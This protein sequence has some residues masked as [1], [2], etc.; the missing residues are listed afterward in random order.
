[1][2]DWN[3]VVIG[4]FGIAA[5]A[6]ATPALAA[7][8]PSV[9]DAYTYRLVN[10][11]NKEL[12]ALVRYQVSGVEPDRVSYTVTPDQAA[13]GVE[14]T[15][16]YSRDGNWLRVPL[17]SHGEAVEYAFATAYPA[18]VFPL[19]PGKS[20]SLRVKASVESARWG[21]RSVRVDGA[22]LGSERVRVPAGEFDTIK[23]RRYVYPGDAD[24]LITETRIVEFDWYAP[25][26]GRVV[27]S[28][29]RSD[30]LD[31]S[32]CNANMGCDYYGS[33][34]V[35]ELAEVRPARS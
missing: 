25:A 22:V 15:E 18:L 13:G 19:E 21:P 32:R 16:V 12:Q 10:G 27:R 1:M 31:M 2:M 23:I 9:G 24:Y 33:W 5:L 29:R 14:R 8:T 35:L 4:A 26:L 28:E 17:E 6:A 3:R 30:W 11:Y 7:G 34:S 20:W